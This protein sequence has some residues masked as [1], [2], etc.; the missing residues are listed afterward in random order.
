MLQKGNGCPNSLIESVDNLS[1]K[2]FWM[3]HPFLL[4][5]RGQVWYYKLPDIKHYLSTGQTT[6]RAAENYVIEVLNKERASV[7][8][9]YTFRKYAE[10]FYSW[11]RCPHIR[12]LRE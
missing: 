11:D 7:P 12:R 4:W 8:R 6:R 3:K 10:P 5:K 9:Y 1:I 2:G